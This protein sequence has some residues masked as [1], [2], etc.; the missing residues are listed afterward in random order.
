MRWL[1][2]RLWRDDWKLFISFNIWLELSQGSFGY[3]ALNRV[4]GKAIETEGRF[5]HSLARFGRTS[6]LIKIRDCEGGLQCTSS[7]I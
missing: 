2:S 5:K 1:E 4:S 3:F 7:Q 6:V